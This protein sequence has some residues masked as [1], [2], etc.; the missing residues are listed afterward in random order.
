MGF[1]PRRTTTPPFLRYLCWSIVLCFHLQC[2][3]VLYCYSAIAI[4]QYVS[5]I[6]ES[7]NHFQEIKDYVLAIMIIAILTLVVRAGIVIYRVVRYVT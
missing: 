4:E 2:F 1:G 5:C 7:L 3:Y 6:F